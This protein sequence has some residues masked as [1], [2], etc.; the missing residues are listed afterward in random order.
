MKVDAEAGFSA[1]FIAVHCRGGKALKTHRP[2]AS[3][4]Q[5]ILMRLRFR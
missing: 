4:W 3:L 2:D 5:R 1:E